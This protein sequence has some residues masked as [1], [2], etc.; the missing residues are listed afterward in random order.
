MTCGHCGGSNPDS[1]R[2]CQTCGKSLAPEP[3]ACP[4]CGTV[5]TESAAFCSACG[6]RLDSKAS[7]PAAQP[8]APPLPDSKPGL[9]SAGETIAPA[10]PAPKPPSD[11]SGKVIAVVLWFFA[12]FLFL[13][14]IDYMSTAGGKTCFVVALLC[15]IVGFNF[16]PKNK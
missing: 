2:F 5:N 3:R 1:A 11:R 9:K 10:I 14:G 13:M 7:P 15:G 4:A 8:T 12:I 6:S 16:W